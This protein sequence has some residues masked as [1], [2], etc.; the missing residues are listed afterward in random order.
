MRVRMRQG[1]MVM[2]ILSGIMFFGPGCTWEPGIDKNK[3][4]ELNRTAQELRASL[5]SDKPCDVPDALL[6]RL[7]SGTAALKGKAASKAERDVLAAYSRL[8]TTYQDGLLL[9]RYR[10][11]LHQFQF[12]PQGRI[13]VSQELDPLVEKYGLLTERHLYRPTGAYWR[14]IDAD[15]IKVIWESAE[16]QIKNIENMVNYN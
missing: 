11:Q 8:M 10:D 2:I 7:A 1:S 5:K 9:C 3:F 4:S 13:Y 14:S 6:Q 16:V 15:S 12:V